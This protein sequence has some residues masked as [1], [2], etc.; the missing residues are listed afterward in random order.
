MRIVILGGAGNFGARIV[1]ALQ[2]DERIEIVVASRRSPEAP[3][4]I[5]APDLATRLRDL[6]PALVIHCIGPFQGQDYRVAQAALEAGAHYI[7]LAD[8]RAFVAGFEEALATQAQRAGR[9]AISG[10]STLPALSSAVVDELKTGL[11]SLE[12][13]E[14]VIA[15]GQRAPRGRA[16][17]E[18]VFSYLGRPFPVWQRSRWR[19]VTGW[20]D[21]R[22]V[23]LS[24]G[25]RWAAACDVPDLALFPVRYGPLETARFHAALEFGVEHFALWM[26]AA[27]RRAG[28]PLPVERWALALDRCAGWLDRWGG[29]EG[30]MLVS[31]VGHTAA[32][33]RI[34]RSWQLRTAAERGPEIPTF[35][36][37]LLAQRLARGE[38]LPTGARACMG[39]L[40]LA[41]FA[42]LFAAW[43]MTT[44]FGESA[45]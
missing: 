15:P 33:T 19:E 23:P 4:D 8:G 6:A 26:L 22:R 14:V 5:D 17:L 16:T 35:A 1:R 29:E 31:I 36:A 9:A 3:I 44:T 25:P 28:L 7:D 24:I 39:L 2:A 10:A 20:M 21:L 32:G 43:G 38:A 27:L 41:D 30:G 45:A 12:S 34:R 11:E 42:P 18:A 40:T 13:I 37:I